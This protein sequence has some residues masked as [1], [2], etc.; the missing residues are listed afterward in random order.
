MHSLPV[1]QFEARPDRKTVLFICT[2]NFYRSRLAEAVFNH[3]AKQEGLNWEALS[4]GLAIKKAPER[5]LS[6]IT[7]TAMIVM[8]IPRNQTAPWKKALT[9]K[10]LTKA[11]LHIALNRV[12]HRQLVKKKFPGWENKI[13]YWNILDANISNPLREIH[14]LKESVIKLIS[15]LKSL[16]FEK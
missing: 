4:R 13:V 14:R 16:S 2:G 12:E 8:G 15:Q 6:I 11:S 7:K 10:D 1:H 3:H 5:D 9:L